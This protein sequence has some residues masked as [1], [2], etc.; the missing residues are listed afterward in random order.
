[1]AQ[2]QEVARDH[3][4][5]LHIM[6]D[7]ND[8][9]SKK[10]KSWEE[11]EQMASNILTISSGSFFRLYT[12][13]AQVTNLPSKNGPI[14]VKNAND[15][16]IGNIDP[17]PSAVVK[18]V[19]AA[20]RIGQSAT[21]F[22]MPSRGR[23]DSYQWTLSD[24]STFTTPIAEHSFTKEG[25]FTG[26]LQVKGPGGEAVGDFSIQVL[27]DPP[28]VAR[29]EFIPKVARV[30]DTILLNDES[31]GAPT[32]RSWSVDAVNLGSSLRQEWRPASEGVKSVTLSIDRGTKNA[33]VEHTINVLPPAPIANFSVSPSRSAAYGET[34][35][36]TSKA[37]GKNLSY[38]WTVDGELVSDQVAFN[39][40]AK[41]QGLHDIGLT[42]TNAGGVSLPKTVTVEVLS[43]DPDFDIAPAAA[44]VVGTK[45]ELRAKATDA[46]LTHGWSING[47]EIGAGVN[48][49]FKPTKSGTIEITHVVS[50]PDG[51]VTKSHTLVVNLLPSIN[52]DFSIEPNG[53]TVDAG[54]KVILRAKDLSGTHGWQLSTG[55]KLVGAEVSFTSGTQS[56]VEIIHTVNDASHMEGKS[57]SSV[58]FIERLKVEFK[59]TPIRGNLP[60]TVSFNPQVQ[61]EASTYLWTFGDGATDDKKNTEHIYKTAG[62]FSPRLTVR[63]HTGKEIKSLEPIV[64][65]VIQPPPAWRLPAIIGGILALAAGG[66]FLWLK[67]GKQ[68]IELTGRLS[69]EG[70]YGDGSRNISGLNYDLKQLQ[71]E[72]WDT[73]SVY[74]IRGTRSGGIYLY[75]DEA[76]LIQLQGRSDF[77]VDGIQFS[78][79]NELI[80]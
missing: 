4:I 45:V 42:V 34:I 31:E 28:L 3:R 35:S 41:K 6:T 50:F 12:L 14:E 70:Q 77:E 15:G 5:S 55:E 46:I 26:R 60:L 62:K 69:W 11:V 30:G 10:L 24:G 32:S 1:M 53:K 27:A 64:I 54:T 16:A 63:S 38:A 71:I 33:V 68:A 73:R 78:Y 29:F 74:V 57:N 36:F 19:P 58:F 79:R 43:V 52:A 7:G 48:Q 21:L 72:G 65:E 56:V 9:N 20:V 61:G 23:I 67:R 39:W 66:A 22:N 76:E 25:V 80:S 59:A 17:A 40:K 75:K 51:K 18:V 37:V 13:G 49:S 47:Q 2:L 44:V 8:E